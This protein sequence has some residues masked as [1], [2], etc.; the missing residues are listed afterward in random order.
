MT[1][2]SVNYNYYCV[3]IS[4][5]KISASPNIFLWFS[6]IRNLPKI[7]PRSFK[8]VAPQTYSDT[9]IHTK[10]D[11]E[12]NTETKAVR[13]RIT[14]ENVVP[15]RWKILVICSHSSFNDLVTDWMNWRQ[16]GCTQLWQQPITAQLTERKQLI[17]IHYM[18]IG[19][20][21]ILQIKH[22]GPVDNT[23]LSKGLCGVH[24]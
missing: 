6:K 12:T 3:I 15:E 20:M 17:Y 11:R 10:L 1:Q 8:N 9:Y 13:R 4:H 16:I 18:H 19:N 2:K 7:F 14:R 23:C 21:M 5:F 22:M 24:M